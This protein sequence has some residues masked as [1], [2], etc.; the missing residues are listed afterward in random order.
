MKKFFNKIVLF[1]TGLFSNLDRWIHEHVQPAIDLVQNLKSFVDSPV[2]DLI[3]AII[4]GNVD[5][6]I[7][8]LLSTSLQ[9]ALDSL[10]VVKIEDSNADLQTKL[11][12]LLEYIKTLSPT[13]QNGVYFKLASEIAKAM[14]STDS[15]KGHSVDLL[16]QMQYSKMKEGIKAEDL[17]AETLVDGEV[18]KQSEQPTETPDPEATT[19]SASVAL[20]NGIHEQW[21]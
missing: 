8:L 1:L 16:V 18:Q 17:P 2:A 11:N 13:M 5:D 10:Q 21:L 14:G 3:T 20:P 15:F 6:S 4:P 12:A 19:E 7:K 9:K